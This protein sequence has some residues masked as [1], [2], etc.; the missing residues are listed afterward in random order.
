[1]NIDVPVK[2]EYGNVKFT[3]TL[4]AEQV[5]SL[6]QFS[7]SFLLAAGISSINGV[8]VNGIPGGPVELDD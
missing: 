3:T 2:D 7:M 6:L 8:V 4:N 1:M 5:Q